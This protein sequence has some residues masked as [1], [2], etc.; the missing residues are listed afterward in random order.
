MRLLICGSRGF[1]SYPLLLKV[2][3]E[4]KLEPDEIIS[5]NARGA[6]TLGELYAEQNK[7]PVKIFPAEWKDHYGKFDRGAG[8]KRNLKMIEYIKRFPDSV[9]LAFWDGNSTGTKH[10]IDCA[11]SQGVRVIVK[12]FKG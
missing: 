1:T 10:S 5:G 2:I 12:V 11:K 3:R 9:V 4:N 8:F 6:D 7:I